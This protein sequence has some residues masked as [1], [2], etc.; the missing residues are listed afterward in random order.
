MRRRR[1]LALPMLAATVPALA[2]VDYP[3]VEPRAF[4]FP[5]DRGAHPEFRIEWWYVTGWVTGDG[6]RD[7]GVQ[8][9]F[10]RN[11]PGVAEASASVFAPR[12]LLFAHAG[13]TVS[14]DRLLIHVWGNRAG[15]NRQLLKQLVHRLRQKIEDDPADPRLVRNV[16]NAGYLLDPGTAAPRAQDA[17]H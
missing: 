5:R 11:R 10:F 3:R 16:P 17:Q 14:T 1:F 12:Q 9:T 2:E 6:G 13:R 8:I 15:G 7:Y 4:V